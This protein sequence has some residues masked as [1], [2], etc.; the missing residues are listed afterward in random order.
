MFLSIII[1]M[2]IFVA[3]TVSFGEST[4]TVDEYGGPAFLAVILSN[5]SSTDITIKVFTTDGSAIGNCFQTITVY[6]T[7]NMLQEE[8]YIMVLD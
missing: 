6:L 8:I 7:C 1:A 4:Y 2:Y 3:P 5:P